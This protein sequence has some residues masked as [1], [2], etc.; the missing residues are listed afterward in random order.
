MSGNAAFTPT[1][2][3]AADN[4]IPSKIVEIAYPEI[5][6]KLQ[7]LFREFTD[8][9]YENGYIIVDTKFEVFLNSK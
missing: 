1:D 5:V 2:K 6:L 7:A 8:F 3:T 9:A 4:P